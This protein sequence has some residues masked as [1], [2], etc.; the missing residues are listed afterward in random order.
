MKVPSAYIFAIPFWDYCTLA[1]GFLDPVPDYALSGHCSASL[2]PSWTD[3]N[4][5]FS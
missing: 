3:Y 2:F 5:D 4:S 1:W